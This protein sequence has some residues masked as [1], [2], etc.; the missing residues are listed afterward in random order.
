MDYFFSEVQNTNIFNENKHFKLFFQG[1]VL[2]S[3]E[4]A[5]CLSIDFWSLWYNAYSKVLKKGKPVSYNL[6]S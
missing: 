6:I 2:Y 5:F 3:F 4:L 1:K